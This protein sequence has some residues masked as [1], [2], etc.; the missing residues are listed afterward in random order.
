MKKHCTKTAKMLDTQ[1]C[2]HIKNAKTT[3]LLLQSAFYPSKKALAKFYLSAIFGFSFMITS[4]AP[5]GSWAFY[6]YLITKI[7]NRNLNNTKF[8]LSTPTG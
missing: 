6:T 8:C 4:V 1:N 5:A 3:K 7:G 2:L